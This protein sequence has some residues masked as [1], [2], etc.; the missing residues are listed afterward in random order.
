MNEFTK[1]ALSVE[2]QTEN[3]N[4]AFAHYMKPKPFIPGDMLRARPG[5]S[6]FNDD[7]VVLYIRTLNKN[8]PHDFEFIKDAIER[9]KWNKLDCMIARLTDT[10]IVFF[11]PFDSDLLEFRDERAP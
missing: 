1:H 8:D 9:A 6:I 10:G 2:A 11:M 3:L 4:A 7:P 5:L